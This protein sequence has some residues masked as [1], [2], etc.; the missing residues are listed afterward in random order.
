MKRVFVGI[1]PGKSGGIAW[2]DEDTQNS[3]THKMPETVTEQLDFW[4]K[5]KLVHEEKE[6]V[7]MVEKVAAMPQ[8]GSKA[9]WTFGFNTGVM[10]CAMQACFIPF[11]LVLPKKW[12][13]SFYM[14]KKKGETNTAWKNRLKNLAQQKF[15]QQKV[16]LWSADALLI[17]DYCHTLK[18]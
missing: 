4:A 12:M 13:D 5:F 10:H 15:P 16:T 8:N 11:D 14:K 3:Y 6:I 17:M 1:D 9:I 18:K 7:A 2:Y